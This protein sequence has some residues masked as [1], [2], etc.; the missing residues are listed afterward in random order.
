[1]DSDEEAEYDHAQVC[2]LARLQEVARQATP[3]YQRW[4][5]EQPG[6]AAAFHRLVSELRATGVRAPVMTRY[7]RDASGAVVAVQ[8][9][10]EG[11]VVGGVARGAQPGDAAANKM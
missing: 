5:R 7:V 2:A 9:Y 8:F 11:Q 10:L 4:H 3:Q 1:M 6:E